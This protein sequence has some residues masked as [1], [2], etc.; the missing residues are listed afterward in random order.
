MTNG[1]KDGYRGM[2]AMSKQMSAQR[3]AKAIISSRTARI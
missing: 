3:L 1:D 2:D